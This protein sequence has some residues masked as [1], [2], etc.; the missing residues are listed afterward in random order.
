MKPIKTHGLFDNLRYLFRKCLK[1]N[2]RI[3]PLLMLYAVMEAVMPFL[4]AYLP[5]VALQLLQDGAG[6]WQA[7]VTLGT[8]A[9]GLCMV[10]AVHGATGA[11]YWEVNNVRIEWMQDLFL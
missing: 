9:L 2:G 5:K 7:V 11:C 1:Y 8:F 3:I 4:L 6:I 10:K